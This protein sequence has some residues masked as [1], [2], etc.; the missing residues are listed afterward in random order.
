MA[1][2]KETTIDGKLTVLNNN[3]HLD[4]GNILYG[5]NADGA[6]RAMVQINSSNEMFFGYGGYKNNEG[7]TYLDGNDVQI[8]SK[9]GIY[10]TDPDAGL[11]ARAYGQNK[12]LW[13]GTY[14][15]TDTHRI[16]LSESVSA[17]PH[18]IVLVWSLYSNGAAENAGFNYI[19]VPKQHITSFAGCGVSCFLTG[20]ANS[21]G[22]SAIGFKYVYVNNASIVGNANNSYAGESNGLT[23]ASNKFVLRQVIGV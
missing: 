21:T 8:R 16:T 2:L 17:Q 10:V 19:F 5:M 23:M 18:G 1:Q 3:I 13:S 20:Y 9:G 22:T 11:S 12:V 15:M 6:D 7:K 14:Y 4:N